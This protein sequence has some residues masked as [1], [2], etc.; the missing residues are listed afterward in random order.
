MSS[1]R[2]LV[3]SALLLGDSRPVRSPRARRSSMHP[4]RCRCRSCGTSR[5]P[6][7]ICSLARAGARA[8][9]MRWRHTA[10]SR[11]TS[12]GRAAGTT[13]SMLA[14]GGGASSWAWRL[15]RKSSF[16]AALGHRVP[17]AGDLLPPELDPD[18]GSRT[19]SAASRPIPAG[20]HPPK[21]A[22]GAGPGARIHSS[23]RSPSAGSSS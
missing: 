13:S 19:Q 16:P 18:R 11:S 4:R 22:S 2:I 9:P 15:S 21:R 10:S 23:A 8:R 6:R 17:P 3:S 12:P 7:A 20:T 1:T 14:A 5:T